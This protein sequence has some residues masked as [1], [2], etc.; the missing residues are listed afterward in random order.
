[1][2]PSD[3]GISGVSES[4]GWGSTITIRQTPNLLTVEYAF[5]ARGD[6]QAPLSFKYA[7]DGTTT[8][9]T[10]MM[11]RG[12]QVQTSKATWEGDK[13]VI[14]TVHTFDHP[15]TGHPVIADVRR[16]L[17][18]ETETP[19]SLVVETLRRGVLGGPDTTTRVVYRKID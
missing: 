1:M 11:G 4:S 3:P 7:L 12:I 5:F 16:T 18:F 13:L 10:V 14:T 17:S 9:N 6:M 19:G 8:K 15:D 2:R